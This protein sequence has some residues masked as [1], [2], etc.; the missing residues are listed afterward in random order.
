[1]KLNFSLSTEEDVM[2]L[3]SV[4]DNFDMTR[5]EESD[6]LGDDEMAV[7]SPVK[8][9]QNESTTDRKPIVFDLGESLEEDDEN[10]GE[11]RDKFKSE[12]QTI[13]LNASQKWKDLGIPERLDSIKVDKNQTKRLNGK[14]K[15]R[16]RRGFGGDRQQSGRQL[17]R[18]SN[19]PFR[20]SGDLRQFIN[21]Q[22]SGTNGSQLI[23]YRTIPSIGIGMNPLLNYVMI[24]IVLK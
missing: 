3:L 15:C 24:L 9:S 19:H 11:E 4:S 5:E 12:R 13:N 20:R 17:N 23:N 18:Q 21:Q 6:L 14:R 1:M 7:D 2:D 16:N 8:K 10:D 22:K